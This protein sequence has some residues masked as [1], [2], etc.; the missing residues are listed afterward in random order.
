MFFSRSSRG[1]GAPFRAV[2]RSLIGLSA[3]A[4]LVTAATGVSAASGG[5]QPTI[6]ATDASFVIP[7]GTGVPPVGTTWMLKLQD[8][9]STKLLGT[10]TFTTTEMQPTS[11]LD[12]AVPTVEGCNFQVDVRTT[13]PGQPVDTKSGTFY[14]DL[15]AAVPGCGT[16]TRP[17]DPTTTTTLPM[18]TPTAPVTHSSVAAVTAQ[19]PFTAADTATSTN[20]AAPTALP[21]TGYNYRFLGELGLLLAGLGL[22][23]MRRGVDGGVVRWSMSSVRLGPV[24]GTH[25]PSGRWRIHVVVGPPLRSEPDRHSSGV[26]GP[27]TVRTS[28]EDGGEHGGSANPWLD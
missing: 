12:I 24:A 27:P 5:V 22:L 15:V 28:G 16:T 3:V 17:T 23:L 4:V 7:Q 20:S 18:T 8:L 21:F 11:T 26:D 14:S 2:G 13:P 1:T 10:A 6:S 19:L 25:R 9:T